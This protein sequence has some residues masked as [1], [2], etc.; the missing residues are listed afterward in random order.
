VIVD[1]ED[2][3]RLAA[4]VGDRSRPHKHVLR[5]RIVL[6]S[7]KRL[8]VARI[9]RPVGVW[10]GRSRADDSPTSPSWKP[11]CYT[12]GAALA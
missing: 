10:P 1:A 8:P 11:R 7:A 5:A 9:A 3:A 6:L 4:V 12:M 2:R